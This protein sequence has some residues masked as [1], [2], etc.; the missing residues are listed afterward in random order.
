MSKDNPPD[1][2]ALYTH[3][4][5]DPEAKAAYEALHG[6]GASG[7]VMSVLEGEMSTKE[8]R[9]RIHK[10]T[11]T[12]ADLDSMSEEE[13]GANRTSILKAAAEGRIK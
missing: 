9:D 11:I 5:N 8:A 4:A 1:L 6:E 12:A 7:H 10:G 13:Y 2:N 3:L